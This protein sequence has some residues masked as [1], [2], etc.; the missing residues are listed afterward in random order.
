MNFFGIPKLYG[1]SVIS[2]FDNILRE[3]NRQMKLYFLHVVL[4]TFLKKCFNYS[5]L[6]RL[7]LKE[8][9]AVYN[10]GQVCKSVRVT[11]LP[12]IFSCFQKEAA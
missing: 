2:I 1:D 3:F 8:S 5:L 7:P 11:Y 6:S 9:V 10:F 12:S 4:L